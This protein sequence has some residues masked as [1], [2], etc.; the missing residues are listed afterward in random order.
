MRNAEVAKIRHWSALVGQLGRSK[1]NLKLILCYCKP[2]VEISTKNSLDDS[3][4]NETMQK[5]L[6]LIV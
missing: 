2:D 1:N 5:V 6:A 3:G 4:S